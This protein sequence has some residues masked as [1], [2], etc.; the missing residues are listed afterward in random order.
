MHDSI[1]K[2]FKNGTSGASLYKSSLLCVLCVQ[3]IHII[4]TFFSESVDFQPEIYLP[5]CGHFGMESVP[6]PCNFYPSYVYFMYFSEPWLGVILEQGT[7]PILQK[8]H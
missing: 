6:H 2:S 8:A 1:W 7:C 5:E 3:R 4:I